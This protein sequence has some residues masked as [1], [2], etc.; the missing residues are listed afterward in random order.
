MCKKRGLVQTLPSGW[1]LTPVYKKKMIIY[2]NHFYY[3]KTM[4]NPRYVRVKLYYDQY[5]REMCDGYFPLTERG[6]EMTHIQETFY[7]DSNG[8]WH[9][10][11]IYDLH[12]NVAD[13]IFASKMPGLDEYAAI[14]GLDGD[15]G[16]KLL[17]ILNKETQKRMGLKGDKIFNN[18]GKQLYPSPLG[19]SPPPP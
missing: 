19:K 7:L 2:H 6:A 1:G 8:C 17:T 5:E 13:K 9:Q 14:K 11:T 10:K 3:D 15:S 16:L 4:D 18:M 12:N